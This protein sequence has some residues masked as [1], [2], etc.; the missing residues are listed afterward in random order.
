MKVQVRVRVKKKKEHGKG[1]VEEWRDLNKQPGTPTA[2][3]MSVLFGACRRMSLSSAAAK[4]RRWHSS[5]PGTVVSHLSF[6]L[7]TNLQSCSWLCRLSLSVTDLRQK[8]QSLSKPT[9]TIFLLLFLIFLLS[10][11]FLLLLLWGENRCRGTWTWFRRTRNALANP[12][13]TWPTLGLLAGSVAETRRAVKVNLQRSLW[14]MW[15]NVLT[16]TPL[17]CPTWPK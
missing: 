3:T 15:C 5:R 7:R 9:S 8:M 2:L 12:R 17:L 4:P 11:L 14:N 10:L 6:S 1:N 16:C 13:K